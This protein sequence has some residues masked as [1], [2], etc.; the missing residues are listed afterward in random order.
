MRSKLWKSVRSSHPNAN[1]LFCA[2]L[3]PRVTGDLN[4]E[5]GCGVQPL[6]VTYSFPPPSR[7]SFSA[8]RHRS[9]PPGDL[10]YF[11]GP[12]CPSPIGLASYGK[13]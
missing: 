10:V 6:L 12:G 3:A 11:C 4:F 9:A 5:L 2:P 7:G 13:K 8:Q 1:R